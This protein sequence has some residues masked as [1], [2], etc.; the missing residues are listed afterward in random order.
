MPPLVQAQ[1]VE[2]DSPDCPDDGAGQASSSDPARDCRP[3][4]EHGRDQVEP[5][6]WEPSPTQRLCQPVGGDVPDLFHL[7]TVDD[8]MALRFRRP[9]SE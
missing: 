7:A 5:G 6:A 3:A 4:P 1:Q 8:R 2:G 9:P